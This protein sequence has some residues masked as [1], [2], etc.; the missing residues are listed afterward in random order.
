[1]NN[2][3]EMHNLVVSQNGQYYSVA[4]PNGIVIAQLYMGNDGAFLLDAKCMD[5]ITKLLARRWNVAPK[6]N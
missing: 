1:M 2:V 5:Y 4:I 3:Y 6:K